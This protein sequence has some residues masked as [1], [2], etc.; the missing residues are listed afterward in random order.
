MRESKTER[1]AVEFESEYGDWIRTIG[2]VHQLTRQIGR[3]ILTCQEQSRF[4]HT[5]LRLTEL[6]FEAVPEIIG[7]ARRG[8]IAPS[9]VLLRWL[10]ELAHLYWYLANNPD[11]YTNWCTGGK[12]RP[13]CIGRFFRDQ[14]IPG[15]RLTYEEWSN[16][17][18]SILLS[19]NN[20][21]IRC[22]TSF[23]KLGN[24]VVPDPWRRMC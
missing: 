12:V 8:A 19:Q 15:W 13:K 21:F 6:C 14:K 2:K 22:C 23:V 9:Y 3:V 24:P 5:S 17:T 7:L 11:Q 20:T 18:L 4:L 1:F 10:V 16:V